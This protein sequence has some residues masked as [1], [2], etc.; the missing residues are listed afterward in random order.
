MTS[1][2]PVTKQELENFTG[3]VE[4]HFHWLKQL[5]DRQERRFNHIETDT[6]AI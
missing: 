5:Y 4:R 6:H 2:D 3:K 1:P